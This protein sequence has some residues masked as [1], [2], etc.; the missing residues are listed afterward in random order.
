[1]KSQAEQLAELAR[2]IDLDLKRFDDVAAI[3][4]H[5][6]PARARETAPP[7]LARIFA[8]LR[9]RLTAHSSASDEETRRLDEVQRRLESL[10]KCGNA[11]AREAACRTANADEWERN[12][13]LAVRAGD[14]DLAR[15]ALHQKREALELAATLERQA[16]TISKAMA[17]Y[18]SAVAAIKA[19]SR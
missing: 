19:S 14:D 5:I 9:H 11:L 1:M 16:V 2:R 4:G 8:K 3:A 15:E 7:W 12:A 10:E 6:E 17:E 13:K 18:T